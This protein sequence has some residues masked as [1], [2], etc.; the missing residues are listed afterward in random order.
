MATGNSRRPSPERGLATGREYAAFPWNQDRV[1]WV[2]WRAA[3]ST[4]SSYVMGF[5]F[6]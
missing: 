2:I 5:P 1:D 6:P 4:R 3:R